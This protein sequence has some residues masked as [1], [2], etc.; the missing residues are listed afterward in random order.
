MFVWMKVIETIG[1]WT[2]RFQA[3]WTAL[4]ASSTDQCLSIAE[5]RGTCEA[6][7]PQCASGYCVSRQESVRS[8]NHQCDSLLIIVSGS[9]YTV[10]VHIVE[11]QY[12]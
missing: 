9:A 6:H 12:I 11:H 4:A 10:D 3:T 5:R 2:D 1:D 7:E 8:V